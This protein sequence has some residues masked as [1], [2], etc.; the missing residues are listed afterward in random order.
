M[1][2]QHSIG[3]P[4]GA[5]HAQDSLHRQRLQGSQQH[6][7]SFDQPS[8]EQLAFF[9]MH[10][11]IGVKSWTNAT[12]LHLRLSSSDIR[13]TLTKW[14]L[15][16]NKSV[17]DTLNTL[18][19]KTARMMI[20]ALVHEQNEKL[21]ASDSPSEWVIAGIDVKKETVKR[22]PYQRDIITRIEIILK[23][24][25]LQMDDMSRA[26][27]NFR[28]EDLHDSPPPLNEPFGRVGPAHMNQGSQRPP[29]SG[30]NIMHVEH[31]GIREPPMRDPPFSGHGRDHD[32]GPMP[33]PMREDFPPPPPQHIQAGPP[34]GSHPQGAP[35]PGPNPHA[36]PPHGA[37]QGVPM[38]GP[39][40]VM[41]LPPPP[42]DMPGGPIRHPPHDP[43]QHPRPM[44][45]PMPPHGVEII[46]SHVLKH[47]K[48]KSK[49]L[50]H[51]FQDAFEHESGSESG[52]SD[53]GSH[54]SSRSVED[55]DYRIIER[56]RSRGRKGSK[57]RARSRS[58]NRSR[59]HGRDN[60]PKIY[61]VKKSHGRGRSDVEAVLDD[62]HKFSS[63][64]SSP[65]SSAAALPTQQIFNIHIDNDNDRERERNNTRGREHHMDQETRRTSN[66]IS[67][68]G[69]S[70]P[71]YT[72]RDK[73]DA[74]PMSRHSSV[75]GSE[76]GS[77]VCDSNSS[78]YTSDDSVFSEP[79]RA[80]M[81]SRTISEVGAQPHLRSRAIPRP[82]EDAY[83]TVY[84]EPRRRQK[85][86][87]PADD[88][89]HRPRGSLHEDRIEP[90][91]SP[92]FQRPPLSARRHSVQMANPFDSRYTAQASR[93]YTD[94]PPSY[95][96]KSQPQPQRYI[97]EDRPDP[98]ELRAM[99]AQ[100]DA[101]NYINQSRR[102][103]A[104]SRRN[105]F[106]SRMDAEADEWAYHPRERVHGAYRHVG[107]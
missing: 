106:R 75:G 86:R 12:P 35:H 91:H 64:N 7:G 19:S 80:R 21:S 77:S 16:S 33:M 24:E 10:K 54:F 34:H 40:N 101:M 93:S 52:H 61:K 50:R 49:S 89:P 107:A 37:P 13:Q 69:F 29:Q 6:F 3:Q 90:L 18:D 60:V 20:E 76:T 38:H 94:V 67:P 48:S 23:T 27:A 8:S 102:H 87:S 5:H 84:H 66:P 92:S 83:V 70:D 88:Y 73:Y 17:V 41:V 74:H 25:P 45:G 32:L 65:R 58:G 82:R 79:I 97:A 57:T 85:Q 2:G 42:H 11:P 99:A 63:K 4:R 47:H 28:N 59:S 30:P 44:S 95:A 105:S 15:N 22:Y 104:P 14:Q 78:F 68:L 9:S 39:Q 31:Q 72:K 62:K 46:D 103:G 96:Y 43:H 36:G 98:F 100:I 71:V 1:P 56:S 81:P 53:S 51:E 55:G 26:N